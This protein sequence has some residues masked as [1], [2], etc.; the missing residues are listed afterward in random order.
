[1]SGFV[2]QVTFVYTKDL[3]ASERF[4]GQL[5]GLPMALDQGTCKIFRVTPGAQIGVCLRPEAQAP[6][7]VI[8]TLVTSDVDGWF[9]RLR[10]EGVE[11]EK[12]PAYNAQYQIYHCFLRD[13][14]GALVEIQRFEDPAWRP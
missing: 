14:A 3:E 5:L 4:Y 7:G 12:A 11:F 9:E 1:M 8:L 10:A 6:E 2:G 13:P